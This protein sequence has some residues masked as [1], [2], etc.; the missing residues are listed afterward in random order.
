MVSCAYRSCSSRDSV[1]K[2]K[3]TGITF[4]RLVSEKITIR[5]AVLEKYMRN[6]LPVQNL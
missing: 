4:H 3:L 5:R 6:I 1:D 2:K